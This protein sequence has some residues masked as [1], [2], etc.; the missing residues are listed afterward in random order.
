[1]YTEIRS[2]KRPLGKPRLRWEDIIRVD[3]LEVGCGGM[4]WIKL[5]E[6]RDRRRTLVNAAMNLQ[7]P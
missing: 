5:A 6:D 4:V 7:V 1:V 3:V 2:G